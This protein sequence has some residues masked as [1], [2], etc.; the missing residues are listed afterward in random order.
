MVAALRA[1]SAEA[2]ADMKQQVL[3]ALAD[4][5]ASYQEV[6]RDMAEAHS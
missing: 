2:W 1:Q 4:L 5:K 3:A 6:R